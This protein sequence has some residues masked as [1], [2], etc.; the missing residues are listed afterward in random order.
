MNIDRLSNIIDSLQVCIDDLKTLALEQP[1]PKKESPPWPEMRWLKGSVPGAYLK[2]RSLIVTDGGKKITCLPYKT[3]LPMEID[4]E[5]ETIGFVS[6][7]IG[8]GWVG[9]TELSNNKQVSNPAWRKGFSVY[10][11]GT[12]QWKHEIGHRWQV[13]CCAE[14]YPGIVYGPQ[15]MPSS[16]K[17]LWMDT[18]T[19]NFN[20]VMPPSDRKDYVFNGAWGV[21]GAK[22]KVFILPFSSP[23]VGVVPRGEKKQWTEIKST[24][25]TGNGSS[26]NM[27]THGR[28]HEGA[29]LVV[30]LPRKSN[31]ILTINPDTEEVREIPLPQELIDLFPQIEKSFDCEVGP[32]GWVYSAP[33]AHPVFFR[34]NPFTDEIEW[35]HLKEELKPARRPHQNPETDVNVIAAPDGYFTAMKRIGNEIYYG[36]AG[37]DKGLKLVFNK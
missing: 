10:D 4:I 2:T 29:N 6:R 26:Q 12:G 33:W 32:D 8:T 17:L 19:Y 11:N 14:G 24:E 15:F 9:H 31:A 18:S 13:R 3:G 28:Y 34:F 35:K 20:V 16:S 30:S 5:K 37:G 36:T 22:G 27:Y 23:Y 1:E 21:V 7:S 25:V